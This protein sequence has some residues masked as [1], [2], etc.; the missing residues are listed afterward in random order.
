[1]G[2]LSTW[3]GL[4]SHP[5][6]TYTHQNPSKK[7]IKSL[8]IFL[9]CWRL[10][11]LRA[12]Q[13]NICLWSKGILDRKWLMQR[14]FQQSTV[15]LLSWLWCCCLLLP[16]SIHIWQENVPRANF[17]PQSFLSLSLSPSFILCAKFSRSLLV[18]ACTPSPFFLV[19]SY[20]S[21]PNIS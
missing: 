13:E 15:L 6:I 14:T 7:R 5:L 17:F 18:S 1:M 9:P 3:Q 19:C 21:R 4:L 2:R 11:P 20:A 10:S 16:Y 12:I 8:L